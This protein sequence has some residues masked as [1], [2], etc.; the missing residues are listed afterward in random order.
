MK[1]GWVLDNNT[2][3][4]L[5]SNGVMKTGWI[6]DRG[7]W[8]YC[9]ISGEMQIGTIKIDGKVYSLNQNGAMQKGVVNING[10]DYIFADSGEA[11]GENI[12]A[13]IKEFDCYG[14]IKTI[15][16]NESVEVS[17]GKI[18]KPNKGSSSSGGS[19]SGGSGGTSSDKNQTFEVKFYPYEGAEYSHKTIVVKK[20]ST[21]KELP[22]YKKHDEEDA[23]A[24]KLK[25]WYIN[26]ETQL[27]SSTPITSDID[28]YPKWYAI[29]GS[30]KNDVI[31]KI[32]LNVQEPAIGNTPKNVRV[33][34]DAPYE[35]IATRWFD[36]GN[37][38]EAG[39]IFEE[40]SRYKLKVLLM[41]KEGYQFYTE[42][43]WFMGA[44]GAKLFVNGERRD[45]DNTFMLS[46]AKFFEIKLDFYDLYN[47]PDIIDDTVEL[48]SDFDVNLWKDEGFSDYY[49]RYMEVYY[50]KY[51]LEIVRWSTGSLGN[52]GGLGRLV[53]E[54]NLEN[55][56]AFDH[57]KEYKLVDNNGEIK[58]VRKYEQ[59][60]TI[61]YNKNT[62]EIK[63]I[64]TGINT[65]SNMIEHEDENIN[66]RNYDVLIVSAVDYATDIY[67]ILN[68]KDDYEIIKDGDDIKFQRK[69]HSGE[70][71]DLKPDVT[72]PSAVRLR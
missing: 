39:D 4:Y 8:Y 47:M 28:V 26:D 61:L 55:F 34:S 70:F 40:E 66:R 69:E 24:Y 59:P 57:M 31:D 58:L 42:G 64:R 14:N 46:G 3:Y 15:D 50:K 37:Q 21:I 48:Q 49:R 5:D 27:T 20:D 25:G 13:F 19:S 65:L 68:N 35:V 22:D 29:N 36:Y 11:I 52:T 10:Q 38:M 2:W 1:T 72:T 32:Y 17:E 54:R 51:N 12:P 6:L 18:T 67:D 63:K 56:Y 33:N 23:K 44:D 53:L 41:A 45:A 7:T 16:T 9:N 60:I 62:L 71:E 43:L 30:N